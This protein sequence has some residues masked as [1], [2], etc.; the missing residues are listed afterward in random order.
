MATTPL[1]K[2][3]RI[4]PGQRI[5]I[6]NAPGGYIEELGSM[7]EDV[8]MAQAAEGTFDFVHLFVK[9]VTDLERLGPVAVDAMVHDGL[10]WI[11]YPKKS[12]KVTTD[13]DPGRGLGCR[14]RGRLAAGDAGFNRQ[15]LVG[16]TFPTRG[17]GWEEWRLR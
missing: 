15:H 16:F 5:L 14:R 4:Q 10:L 13:P 2:K 1:S 7:P 9:N 3:L 12:S 6:L 8:E 17:A 11:S